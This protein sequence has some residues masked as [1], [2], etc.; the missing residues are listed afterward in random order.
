[1]GAAFLPFDQ[2]TPEQHLY[3]VWFFLCAGLWKAPQWQPIS[4]GGGIH[5]VHQGKTSSTLELSSGASED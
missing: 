4:K 5:L 2:A 3:V 1:M